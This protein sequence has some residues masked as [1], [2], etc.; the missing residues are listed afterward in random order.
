MAPV[1]RGGFGNTL[2]AATVLMGSTL[3]TPLGHCTKIRLE[4]KQFKKT[5]E[6]LVKISI[7]FGSETKAPRI[8]F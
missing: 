3:N 5:T 2:C 1:C 8:S 4:L 7:D 6:N